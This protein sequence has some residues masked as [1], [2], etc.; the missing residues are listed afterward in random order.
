M[1]IYNIENT[2]EFFETLNE[3][4][5]N[6]ELVNNQGEHIE[7]NSKKGSN[8]NILS[9]T[10]VD[11]IIKEMELCFANKNDAVKIFQ[12]LSGMHNVA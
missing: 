10:Y 11:G 4:E 8:L 6:V 2:K 3:C 9:E 7:L 1:K 5:G 12:F